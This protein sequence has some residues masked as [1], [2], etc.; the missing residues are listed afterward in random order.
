MSLSAATA[1]PL[2]KILPERHGGDDAITAGDRRFIRDVLTAN[3]RAG[4]LVLV[5]E[6]VCAKVSLASH[7]ILQEVSIPDGVDVRGWDDDSFVRQIQTLNNISDL[8]CHYIETCAQNDE[9]GQIC[10]V[11]EKAADYQRAKDA[12]EAV[13]AEAFSGV[14]LPKSEM[15]ADDFVNCCE[16]AEDALVKQ[17]N[18]LIAR[19][20]V[21]R[22][23]SLIGAIGMEPRTVWVVGGKAHFVRKKSLS[24]TDQQEALSRMYGHFQS[25]GISTFILKPPSKKSTSPALQGCNGGIRGLAEGGVH[26]DDSAEGCVAGN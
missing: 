21:S 4:D 16:H 20:F 9:T 18:A 7:P 19:N 13:V 22:A 23:D 17:V 24:H 2:V 1:S 8:F 5:E 10:V 3:L 14:E 6:S 12:L 25:N 15:P 26:I 11:P